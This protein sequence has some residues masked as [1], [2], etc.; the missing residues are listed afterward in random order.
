MNNKVLENYDVIFY[1][2]GKN[3]YFIYK[4]NEFEVNSENMDKLNSL[5]K[6][7]FIVKFYGLSKAQVGR[8]IRDLISE[9]VDFKLYKIR[10]ENSKVKEYAASFYENKNTLIEVYKAPNKQVLVSRVSKSNPYMLTK[11]N[12]E[13]V[14][15]EV[16]KDY[17]NKNNGEFYFL[18]ED[19]TDSEKIAFK[20][21]L[22]KIECEYVYNF[23]NYKY[24]NKNK[25][26]NKQKVKIR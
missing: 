6:L 17:I 1:R 11:F 15:M 23:S 9:E 5:L 13:N 2:K 26:K 8:T 4:N 20:E 7:P 18:P 24:G 21:C 14:L 10:K 19:L 16:P 22:T 25:K 12:N 3:Y